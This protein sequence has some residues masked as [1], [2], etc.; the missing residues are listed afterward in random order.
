MLHRKV[1]RWGR[2][3]NMK[4]MHWAGAIGALMISSSAMAADADVRVA[5]PPAYRTAF[6]E[7]A[8]SW[9]GIYIGGHVGFGLT[10]PRW[11]DPVA[12]SRDLGGREAWG[13]LGGGQ[14][15]FNWQLQSIV[16]GAELEGSWAD[17]EGD[18]Q[19]VSVLVNPNTLSSQVN[20]I[21]TATGRIGFAF[22]QLLVYAKGG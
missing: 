7:P 8:F 14:V 11:T 21:A 16:V 6:I 3:A 18:H 20:G 2:A 22:K 9:T 15:G 10:S 1:A 13:A 5:S 4:K 12:G 19:D 17:L